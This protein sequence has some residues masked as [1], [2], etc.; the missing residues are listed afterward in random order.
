[1]IYRVLIT[2]R[3]EPLAELSKNLAAGSERPVLDFDMLVSTKNT[4]VQTL[5]LGVKAAK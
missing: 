4:S 5:L 1:M 3:H 2:H